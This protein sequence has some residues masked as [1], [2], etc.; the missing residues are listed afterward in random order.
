[1]KTDV[2]IIRSRKLMVNAYIEL[3]DETDNSNIRICHICEKAGVSRPT[4]YKNYSEKEDIIIQHLSDLFNR[5]FEIVK[6]RHYHE[7]KA[8]LLFFR[9]C[10]KEWSFFKTAL[11]MKMDYEILTQLKHAIHHHMKELASK[12]SDS[13]KKSHPLITDDSYTL[14]AFA[15][16]IYMTLV[17]WMEHE[18]LNYRQINKMYTELT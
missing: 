16:K 13:K 5:Y 8:S 3:L 2:R 1:M 18:D 14:Y 17:Y 7:K 11:K 6:N 12:L 15:G 4:F 9:I 10:E